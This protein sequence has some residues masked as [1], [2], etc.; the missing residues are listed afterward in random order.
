MGSYSTDFVVSDTVCCR[1]LQYGLCS[2]GENCSQAHSEAELSEWRERFE[3]HK[4]ELM[5]QRE[6]EQEG[7]AYVERLMEKLMKAQNQQDVVSVC[8]LL[9]M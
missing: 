7:G 6:E 2:F 3:V 9:I 4:K 5:R 1:F 8:G